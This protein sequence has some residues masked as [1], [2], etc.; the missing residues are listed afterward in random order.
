MKKEE[1]VF[2]ELPGNKK[3]QGCLLLFFLW[4]R[5]PLC[6]HRTRLLSARKQKLLGQGAVFCCLWCFR[7]WSF[8]VAGKAQVC[9]SVCRIKR[10]FV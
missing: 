7:N 10:G 9:I 6:A 5:E 1:D 8:S 2:K 4:K 3:L